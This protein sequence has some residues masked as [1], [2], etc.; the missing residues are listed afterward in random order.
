MCNTRTITKAFSLQTILQ[1]CL[2]LHCVGCKQF[3]TYSTQLLKKQL[4]QLKNAKFVSQYF[5]NRTFYEIASLLNLRLG[6][7][8]CNVKLFHESAEKKQ[9][10]RCDNL[11]LSLD[12]VI[13]AVGGRRG[14]EG[15]K[16]R[17]KARCQRPNEL[18]TD[19]CL[20]RHPPTNPNRNISTS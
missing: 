14:G 19:D 7:L 11:T 2:V 18:R 4:L 9:R 6:S 17:G 8:N 1:F 12:T 10:N 20:I 16:G 15:L 3:L 13:V 5:V